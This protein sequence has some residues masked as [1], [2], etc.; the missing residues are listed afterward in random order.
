[1]YKAIVFDI[2]ETLVRYNIPLNWSLLSKPALECV[3]KHCDMVLSDE[4][5]KSAQI[6]LNKYNTRLNPREYEVSSDDIFSEIIKCWN[7]SENYIDIV[8]EG[9]YSYFRRD[10]KVFDDVPDIL[11]ALKRLGIKTA[12]LSD[13]AYGMD[14]VYALEDISEVISLIDF[15]LTSNDVGYRK[16]NPTGLLMLSNMLGVNPQEIIFVGD[17]EKDMTCAANAGVCGVLINRTEDKKEYG[18][19]FEIKSMKKLI[20]LI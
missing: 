6:V 12:T 10:A 11:S 19:R 13:V 18:Q 5:I 2:G 16:P 15:P 8:K 4:D 9:Y 3:A 20:D 17:E 1:M 7:I 14:N